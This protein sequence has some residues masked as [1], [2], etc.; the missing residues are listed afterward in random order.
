MAGTPRKTAM[1]G[2]DGNGALRGL[3]GQGERPARKTAGDVGKSAYVRKSCDVSPE[4]LPMKRTS[5]GSV[6]G[7]Q[8]TASDHDGDE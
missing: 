1:A 5:N 4:N 7:S 6:K 3:S 8:P 2:V